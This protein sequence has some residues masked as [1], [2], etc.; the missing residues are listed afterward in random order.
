MLGYVLINST[1]MRQL[2]RQYEIAQGLP[3]HSQFLLAVSYRHQIK[4]TMFV[5]L[6][7]FTII[8]SEVSSYSVCIPNYIKISSVV[9]ARLK[10]KHQNNH[11]QSFAFTIIS[12]IVLSSSTL[13]DLSIM[14]EKIYKTTNP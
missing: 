10:D 6:Y 1:P 3:S 8:P 4:S 9:S 5:L 14:H 12:V 7:V 11:K 2:L 13:F